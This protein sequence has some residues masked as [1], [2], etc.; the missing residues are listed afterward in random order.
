MS[1]ERS[2][3]DAV[4]RAAG[5][6]MVPFGGWEMPLEY[7][8][9]TIAEHLACR[10]DAVVFDVS[11]LGTVRV[12]GAGALDALQSALTNDLGKIAPGPG[13]VHPPARRRRRLGARRHHRVVAP[14]PTTATTTCST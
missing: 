8:T 11:H 5:A 1:L 3:L 2:P 9:G 13:P 4:H 6:R 10:S 12:A 7:P 14:R